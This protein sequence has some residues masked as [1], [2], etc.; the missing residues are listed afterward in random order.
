MTRTTWLGTLFGSVCVC[1]RVCVCVMCP[2]SLQRIL[3]G[4]RYVDDR[5]RSE[6]F[7]WFRDENVVQLAANYARVSR[8]NHKILLTL[9]GGQDDG[10]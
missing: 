3:G 1:A 9:K 7:R 2:H 6:E 5:Y 4:P 10:N 8:C